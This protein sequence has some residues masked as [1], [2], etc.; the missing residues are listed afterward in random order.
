MSL[1][2]VYDISYH[3][4]VNEWPQGSEMMV[5]H[6]QQQDTEAE[7]NLT[8]DD[9]GAVCSEAVDQFFCSNGEKMAISFSFFPG[10]TYHQYLVSQAC[11]DDTGLF[12]SRTKRMPIF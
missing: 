7:Q 4:R 11:T 8:V 12:Q 3:F 6:S 9:G 2:E 5:R 1:P 10:I